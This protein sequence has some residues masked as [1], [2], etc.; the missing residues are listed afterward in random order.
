MA[1]IDKILIKVYT[2]FYFDPFLISLAERLL[3]LFNSYLGG[4]KTVMV[5]YL[6]TLTHATN[7]ESCR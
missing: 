1:S 4:G 6:T 7:I 2:S 3:P 5:I